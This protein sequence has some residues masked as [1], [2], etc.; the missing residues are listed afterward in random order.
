MSSNGR[1]DKDFEALLVFLQ[2]TRGFDFTAY[3]RS[4]L[5]RRTTKRMHELGIESYG[6]YLDHLQVHP[7]EFSHLFNTILINVTGFFRDREA[8]DF[9]GQSVI[10]RL[11]EQKQTMEGPQGVIRCWCAGTASGEEAYSLAMLL[12]EAL[13]IDAFRQRVKIY[14]TDVDE[15]AL[16][17]ARA[18]GYTDRDLAGVDE[19]Y[20][21]R[22]F[23]Q[24]GHRRVFRADLRRC[25]IFGR[26][27]LVQDAPISRLDLLIC[28]NTL[29]YFTAEA[30]A[31]ILARLH[32][33]LNETGSLFLGKAEMLL[34]HANLFRP[35][36]L[37]HRVFAK[38][39]SVSL[40]DRVMLVAEAGNGE[41]A[42]HAERQ[43][44]MLELSHESLP[45]AQL[46]VDPAGQV[47][48]ANDRA[49]RWLHVNPRD[50]GLPL[51][52]LEVSYR[53]VEL[54]S[55]IE[56]CYAERRPVDRTG[57][58]RQTDSGD[59]QCFDLEVRPLLDTGDQ[60]I[61]C[62]ITYTDMTSAYRLQEDLQRSRQELETAYE[63][64]Q[65]TNEELETTNEELQSTVEE[66]ETTNEELQ[67]SNEE[68]ET[69]NEELEST[70]AEL[71][72]I[73]SELRER[74]DEVERVNEFMESI[75]RSV[76]LGVIVVDSRLRVKMWHGRSHDLWGLDAAEV[77]DRPLRTLDFGLP[78]EEVEP[79]VARSLSEPDGVEG[80]TVPATNR[81]GRHI[82][83]RIISTGIPIDRDGRGV[84]LLMEEM[85]DDTGSP[86]SPAV[87][88]PTPEAPRE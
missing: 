1:E 81:R 84:L 8:W 57:L 34:T 51:R 55:L 2:Q 37:R 31:R 33:A 6:Q 17:E 21:D 61:G 68:L 26:H 50:L 4:T 77:Y 70:N 27:D 75:L 38:V 13:G 39:P 85:R 45:V 58:M 28:R 36:D 49:R 5:M 83:V 15:D 67:S 60:L 46:V 56:Q 76:Q 14:A 88:T 73:N 69:M 10:P 32:Y 9:L 3:K 52:D 78:L 47:L 22:Y 80:V 63:E 42:R 43:V 71:Q 16:A 30:Q 82:Q 12:A 66:L 20:R 23:E 54:R 65:S 11:L 62:S 29:M 86:S 35:I 25:L 19:E 18:G 87:R 79:V 41:G 72:A 64:L 44:R 24:G 59:T 74:T 40:R 53:P 7:D 48:I